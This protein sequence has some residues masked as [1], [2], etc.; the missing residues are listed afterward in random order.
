MNILIACDKFKGSLDATGVCNTIKNGLLEKYPMA[1]FRTIPLADGGD[2]TIAVLKETLEGETRIVRTVDP[3]NRKIEA[4][5]FVHND[6]AYIELALAS[7]IALLSK[8]EYDPGQ[9]NTIGT[10]MLI[11]NAILSGINHIVLCLGGSCTNDGGIGILSVV[12]FKFLDELG[13][14]LNP[15]GDGLIK[16]DRIEKEEGL[17]RVRFSILC[18]VTNPM[19]GPTGAAYTFAKQKGANA[20]QIEKLDKGLRHFAEIIRRQTGGDISDVAGGGAAGGIAGGLY[21]LLG[22]EIIGGFD[23][24]KELTNL[25]EAVQ[26]ADRVITGEG[27]IDN[28]SMNGKVIGGI[29]NLCDKHQKD[30]FAVVGVNGL[31]EEV[32]AA[33]SIK[34]IRSIQSIESETEKTMT[35]PKRYIR[36]LASQ[37]DLSKR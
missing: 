2:G 16:I 27:K 15:I 19:Y 26:W 24:I 35:N 12:G 18:D 1:S 37:L 33:S 17:S 5:Y 4:E 6:T 31:D 11:N 7:G 21:G 8:E 22:A 29:S 36:E 3:S 14:E 30:L 10:G 13:R 28:T 20:E 25:E 9:R 34:D 32:R 23:H